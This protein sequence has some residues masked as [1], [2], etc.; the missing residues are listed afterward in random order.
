M[1]FIHEKESMLLY[2]FTL[3][4]STILHPISH[5]S[6]EIVSFAL[7]SFKKVTFWQLG[8]FLERFCELF[9]QNQLIKSLSKLSPLRISS[10][11]FKSLISLS[12]TVFHHD[13]TISVHCF[14]KKAMIW[15]CK[16]Q[17]IQICNT[18][19]WLKSRLLE[20]LEFF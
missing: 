6:I 7:Y 20:Y 5:L 12:K 17:K 10:S 19:A 4:L 14:A 15:T 11:I 16:I 2:T 8:D 1:H 9:R 18:F 13:F 3:V